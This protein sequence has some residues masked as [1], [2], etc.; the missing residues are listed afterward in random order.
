MR[1]LI[2]AAAFALAACAQKP[3]PIAPRASRATAS[4][5][6]AAQRATDPAAEVQRL[7]A[8]P[9]QLRRYEQAVARDL[10]DPQSARFSSTYVV[11]SEGTKG[12]CGFVR[13]KNDN[14]G[15]AGRQMFY[16][17]LVD[18]ETASSPTAI[19][20]PPWMEPRIALAAIRAK[21]RGAAET[22]DVELTPEIGRDAGKRPR[23]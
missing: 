11:E 15:Y 16:A 18:V 3:D 17:S 9:A 21:C 7:Q 6:A 22:A 2:L 20:A 4:R 14:G 5:T 19:A 8:T 23:G 13:E 12:L 1:Y 10:R